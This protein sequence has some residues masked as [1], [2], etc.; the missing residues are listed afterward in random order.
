MG[1]SFLFA[2]IAA[3]DCAESAPHDLQAGNGAFL[4]QG[5]AFWE[6]ALLLFKNERSCDILLDEYGFSAESWQI[7]K[8]S[9]MLLLKRDAVYKALLEKS[10]KKELGEG[11][12]MSAISLAEGLLDALKLLNSASDSFSALTR[13]ALQKNLATLREVLVTLG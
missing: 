6:N 7:R 12:V 1:F 3:K 10:G 8:R 4:W 13:T 2:G 5:A 11:E 9:L